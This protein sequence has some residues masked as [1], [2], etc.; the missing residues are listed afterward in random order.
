MKENKKKLMKIAEEICDQLCKWPEKCKS[1]AE[2]LRK[3]CDNGCPV[4]KL[5]E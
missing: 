5:L 4:N 1:E 2:L 3:H